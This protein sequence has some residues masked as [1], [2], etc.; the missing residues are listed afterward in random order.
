MFPP[1]P[2]VGEADG[3]VQDRKRRQN[4]CSCRFQ[5]AKFLD[6]AA[7]HTV[8]GNASSSGSVPEHELLRVRFVDLSPDTEMER[9]R[10][11]RGD[12]SRPVLWTLRDVD[13]ILEQEFSLLAEEFLPVDLPRQ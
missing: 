13:R 7:Q 6:T 3:H 5:E 8:Q 9:F 10:P 1:L 2:Y 12:R 4:S 11:L